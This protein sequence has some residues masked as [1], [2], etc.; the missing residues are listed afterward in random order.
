MT[1]YKKEELLLNVKN[2]NLSYGDK[3]ILTNINL[4]VYDVVRPNMTQGQVVSI[5]GRSGSGKSTLFRV[6]SGLQAFSTDKIKGNVTGEV[7]IGKNQEQVQK[8]DMGVIFQNYFIFPWRRI[9]KIF[10][11][12]VS[13]NPCVKP[14]DR[15]SLIDFYVSEFN[16]KDH[17]NKFSGHLSGGQKQRAAIV[18]QL[19]NGSNFLLLD[20]PFSGL[21]C[22]ILDNVVSV[23][24]K[25]SLSDDLKTL[26]LVTHDIDTAV[27][28]SDTVFVLA[29]TPDVEGSTIV[30]EIDLISR[31]LAWHENIKEQYQF[32]ETVKEI[33]SLI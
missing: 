32:K 18:Q 19:L 10:L 5:L 14:E 21:D 8:G 6:L 11:D 4:Q 22:I 26:I 13:L 33:K 20:E 16:L 28:L 2:V 7:L 30:K 12:S 25:V 24:R 3:K 27:T 1:D 9:K 23:L 29:K 17:I 31:D 15:Q